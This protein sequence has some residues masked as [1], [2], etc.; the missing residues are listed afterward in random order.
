MYVCTYMYVGDLIWILTQ[1]QLRAVSR[2]MQSLMDAAVRT[3]KEQAEQ[4]DSDSEG[5][6]DS[7][8]SE[9]GTQKTGNQQQ[10]KKKRKSKSSSRRD[11]G[12]KERIA[13]YQ[14]GKLNLPSYEVIQNTF[15][16]KTGKMD[17]QF[18]DD[19]SN[20]GGV[21]DTVQGSMLFQ[22][23]VCTSMCVCGGGGGGGGAHTGLV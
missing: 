9:R 23:Y 5:S 18:C 10:Q 13:Q 1:S 21:T 17:L 3:H 19:T 22:V 15:H 11:K 4:E 6:I 2:L 12:V 16:F 7:V 20:S 14:D 8:S